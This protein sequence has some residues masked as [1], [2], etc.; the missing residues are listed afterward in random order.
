MNTQLVDSILQVVKALPNEEKTLL[1]DRIHQLISPAVDSAEESKR[2]EASTD[3]PVDPE[4]WAVWET[5]GDDAVPGQLENTS[6]HH[7]RYLYSK[8]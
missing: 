2:V 7:D 1:I 5:F 4:A 3:S 6:I 8:D